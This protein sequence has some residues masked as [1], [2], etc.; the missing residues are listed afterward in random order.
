MQ[1]SQV[2]LWVFVWQW[3]DYGIY[4]EKEAHNISAKANQTLNLK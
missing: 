4:I 3:M 1:M 2:F